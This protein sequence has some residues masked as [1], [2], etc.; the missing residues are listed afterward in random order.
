[1]GDYIDDVD[2]PSGKFGSEKAPSKNFHPTI[3]P[4]N[5]MQYL[6]RL[7]TPPNGIVLDPFMGSGT[8]GVACKLEGVSFVGIEMNPEYHEI[9]A[10]RIENF[11]EESELPE[12]LKIEDNQNDENQKTEQLKFNF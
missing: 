7:I 1:M 12:N 9:A 3:K 6:V 8:T 5:L 11:I 2:S 10:A 4:I